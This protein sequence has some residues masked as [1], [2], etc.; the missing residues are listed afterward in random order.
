MGE[1]NHIEALVDEHK[2]RLSL[3]DA[4]LLIDTNRCSDLE[5][6]ASNMHQFTKNHERLVEVQSEQFS[7]L[8]LLCKQPKSTSVHPN[9]TAETTS[10]EPAH[11]PPK[12]DGRKPV[13]FQEC[14]STVLG[15]LKGHME[16]M[17]VENNECISRVVDA[18]QGNFSTETSIIHD[19]L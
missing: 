12:V 15:E 17:A 1:Q 13:E 11:C 10:K 6:I 18:L 19:H 7:K 8:A 5:T 2:K 3:L 14:N 9:E 16:A 4:E